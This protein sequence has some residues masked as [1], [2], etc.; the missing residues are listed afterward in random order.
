MG[1]V[2]RWFTAVLGAP[3]RPKEEEEKIEGGEEVREPRKERG[4]WATE[5]TEA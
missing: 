1:E 4:I 5:S 3:Q 2:T